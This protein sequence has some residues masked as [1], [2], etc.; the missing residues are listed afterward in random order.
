MIFEHTQDECF[1][2]GIFD[3]RDAFLKE[4]G[5]DT[6]RHNQKGEIR[7]YLLT[8]EEH[9]LLKIKDDYDRIYALYENE[10]ISS[11]DKTTLEKIITE[12]HLRLSDSF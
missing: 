7:Y 8:N 2:G 5:L 11:K 3:L 10:I 1:A 12:K 6:Y 4:Y 9:R